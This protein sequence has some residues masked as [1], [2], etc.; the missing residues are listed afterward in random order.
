MARCGGLLAVLCTRNRSCGGTWE[1]PRI[2]SYAILNLHANPHSQN[3]LRIGKRVGIYFLNFYLLLSKSSASVATAM[4]KGWA[5][6]LIFQASLQASRMNGCT[7]E[8]VASGGRE[9]LGLR[10]K[11][12]ITSYKSSHHQYYNLVSPNTWKF[13]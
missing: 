9:T 11:A 5:R 7:M 12:R 13:Y 10:F 1:Y 3:G 6:A 8:K 2:N 4:S